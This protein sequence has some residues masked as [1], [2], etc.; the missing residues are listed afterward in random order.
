VKDKKNFN[1]TNRGK[2]KRKNKLTTCGYF[3]KRMRDS[4][5]IANR[6]FADYGPGDPRKWTVMINPGHESLFITCFE[7]K[8]F[9]GQKMFEISDGGV[10]IPKNLGLNTDSIEV[11]LNYLN[12]FNVLIPNADS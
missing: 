11:L 5:F 12:E 2:G 4:G 8:D 9:L 6:I 7:N 3:L 10:R 1:N